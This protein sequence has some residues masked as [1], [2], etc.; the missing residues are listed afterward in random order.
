[1]NNRYRVWANRL[2]VASFIGLLVGLYAAFVYAPTEATMGDVQRI[3]YFHVASASTAFLAFFVVFVASVGYLAKRTRGWDNVAVAAAEIGI[4]F[5]TLVLVTGPLWGK[6][7]WGTWWTWDPRL[8][9]TLVLWLIYVGYMMLRNALD[10]PAKRALVSAVFGIVGFIDVPIVFM[11]I[12]WW[13]TIHPMVL[14][15]GDLQ[16]A[17]EMTVTL[18]VALVAFAILFAYLMVE[19]LRL[20]NSEEELERLKAELMSERLA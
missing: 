13:R 2:G 17:P 20:Q 12:R 11:S 9:T 5:C 7:A 3:F 14:Q 10:D 6:P 4:V 19:R 8:T 1:M 15:G 18:V 16:L